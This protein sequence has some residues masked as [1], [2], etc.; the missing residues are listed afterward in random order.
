MSI[1]K[2]QFNRPENTLLF[3]SAKIEKI[4]NVKRLTTSKFQK[5][6]EVV[7]DSKLRNALGLNNKR[8]FSRSESIFWQSTINLIFPLSKP[9]LKYSV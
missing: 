1:F 3:G 7:L 5:L 8:H 6:K 4:T 9:I 2:D